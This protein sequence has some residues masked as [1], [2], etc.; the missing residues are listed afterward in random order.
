MDHAYTNPSADGTRAS[1]TTGES[2]Q[3]SSAGFV[4]FDMIGV[5]EAASAIMAS[6]HGTLLLVEHM[7]F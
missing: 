6:R 4:D 7:S 5:C 3:D 2:A 1:S